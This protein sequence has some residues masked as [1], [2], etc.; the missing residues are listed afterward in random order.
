ML[1]FT[2]TYLKMR[3]LNHLSYRKTSRTISL[4]EGYSRDGRESYEN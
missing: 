3:Y 1:V 4:Y 2:T